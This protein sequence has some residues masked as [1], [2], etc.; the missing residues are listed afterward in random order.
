MGILGQRCVA[1]KPRS[2]A[3]KDYQSVSVSFPKGLFCCQDR[4][5]NGD[6]VA[7][8][9]RSGVLIR[10]TVFL[11]SAVYSL[12]FAIVANFTPWIFGEMGQIMISQ[13]ARGLPLHSLWS[14]AL[15]FST[16][17]FYPKGLTF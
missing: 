13:I 15:C 12:D 1:L 4:M 16:L 10:R 6:E 9:F 8:L 11:L 2:V 7:K 14:A 5:V 3:V 17:G